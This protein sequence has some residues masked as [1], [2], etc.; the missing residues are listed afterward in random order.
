MPGYPCCHNINDIENRDNYYESYDSP[1]V[2]IKGVY[3]IAH[4]QWQYNNCVML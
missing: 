3:N 1:H 2:T 4:L